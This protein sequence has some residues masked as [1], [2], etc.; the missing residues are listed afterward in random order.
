MRALL[1][2]NQGENVGEEAEKPKFVVNKSLQTFSE[3]EMKML[4]HQ[5]GSTLRIER[6]LQYFF[7]L[8]I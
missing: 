6:T 2:I 4:N 8:H 1:G 7:L 5:K 3:D